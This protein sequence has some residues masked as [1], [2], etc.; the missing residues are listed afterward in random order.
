M[1]EHN[2]KSLSKRKQC[3]LLGV[4]RNRLNP[5]K[6]KQTKLDEELMR[7]IDEIHMKCPFYGQR[8]IVYILR[9]QGY[10]VGRKRIRRLMRIMGIESI[11]PKPNT[12]KPKKGHKIYPYLLK[13][14]PITKSNQVWCADITYIPMAKGHVYLVAIMDWH[15]KAVLSWKLSNSMDASFCVSALEEAIRE[16]GATPQIFNTDQG[17][18]FTGK[19][20]ITPSMDGKGRWVDNVF[21]ERLWRSLKYERIRL[22]SYDTVRDVR[23]HVDSWMKFYNHERPHQGLDMRSPWNVYMENQEKAA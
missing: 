23:G 6:L 20:K 10:T 19:K 11:A 1:I 2:H 22:Y 7:L 15:S 9:K 8:N 21:I 18:Q 3:K 13:N 4:N 5:R 12:S 16:T 14:L 17:S